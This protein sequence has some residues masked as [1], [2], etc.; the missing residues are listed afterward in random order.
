MIVNNRLAAKK[1]LPAYCQTFTLHAA[2]DYRCLVRL[3]AGEGKVKMIV[4]VNPMAADY[5]E[6]LHV[7]KF[8]ELTQEVQTT[9]S[10]GEFSFIAL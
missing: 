10:A 1:R 9:R 3:F 4:C 8:A 2:I 5:D 7:M 6:T